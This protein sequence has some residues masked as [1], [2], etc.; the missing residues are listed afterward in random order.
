MNH[1]DALNTYFEK[2]L[3]KLKEQEDYWRIPK[4]PG[5]N[6]SCEKSYLANVELKYYLRDKWHSAPSFEKMKWTNII[7]SDW[8]GIRNNKLNTLQ[9]YIKEI[10]TP[11]PKTLIKGV[12]SYSKLFSIVD[13]EKYAI[14]DA[15]VAVSLNMIQF[16]YGANERWAFNY[17]PGRNKKIDFVCKECLKVETLSNKQWESISRDETYD[18]YLRTLKDCRSSFPQYQLYDLEMVLFSNA[19]RLCERLCKEHGARMFNV[20]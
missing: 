4:I 6:K 17:I 1:I 20:P 19:E 10:A 14:Y 9:R 3:P 11:K 18:K 8:G 13:L 12:A 16:L 7:V 15:R 2:E 5:F